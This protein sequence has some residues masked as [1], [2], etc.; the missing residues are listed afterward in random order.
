[1]VH[2]SIKKSF[3]VKAWIEVEREDRNLSIS[4]KFKNYSHQVLAL[5][6]I[7][8]IRKEGGFNRSEIVQKGKC[9]SP[10]PKIISLSRSGMN[11][12]PNEKLTISLLVYYDKSVIA[13]D[14][15]VFQ[16]D[17]P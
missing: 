10:N 7:L 15:V 11:I 6:Y 4:A 5:D 9:T 3:H 1:M 8:E 16:V 14:L 12:N 13:S 2:S 17:N